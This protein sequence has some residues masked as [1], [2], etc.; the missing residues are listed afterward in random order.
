MNIKNFGKPSTC[1]KVDRLINKKL[2]GHVQF[3]LTQ[4]TATEWWSHWWQG[5]KCLESEFA[6]IPQPRR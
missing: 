1:R 4:S 3:H 6:A 2:L 5:G